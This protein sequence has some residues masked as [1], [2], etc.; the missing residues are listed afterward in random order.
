M[1]QE[2]LREKL[3]GKGV[4]EETVIEM[5]TETFDAARELG[6]TATMARVAV[7]LADML[8]MEPEKTKTEVSEEFSYDQVLSEKAEQHTLTGKKT[9]LIE[10]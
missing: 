9:Q 4:E 2:K 10:D 5:F 1:V 8:G 6:Q 3:K 7:N